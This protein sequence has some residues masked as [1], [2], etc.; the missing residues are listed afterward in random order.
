MGFFPG[1]W[2]SCSFTSYGNSLAALWIADLKMQAAAT[3]SMSKVKRLPKS[4]REV[5]V[6]P[7]SALVRP[8]LNSCVQFQ[9]P[10][11]KKDLKQLEN[12]Q[13]RAKKMVNGPEGH[14]L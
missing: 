8:H 4:L 12:V 10:W 7:Y 3:L 5:I 1:S 14:F 2:Y 9:V 13:R 11:Y 6:Y